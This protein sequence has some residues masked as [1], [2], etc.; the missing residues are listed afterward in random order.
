MRAS[1]TF[2]LV[3]ML[4]WAAAPLASAAESVLE[5]KHLTVRMLSTAERA[6]PGEPMIIGLQLTHDE[7]WHTY[8]ENPGDT[9]FETKVEWILPEGAQAGEL[10]WPMPERHMFSGMVYFGFGGE[11]LLLAEITPPETLEPG[12]TFDIQAKMQWLVCADVCIPGRGTA[13]LSLPVSDDGSAGKSDAAEMLL[14]AAENAPRPVS[15]EG[16][17]LE[18]KGDSVTLRAKTGSLLDSVDDG[19]AE[20]FPIT[21][22]VMDNA[23]QPAIDIEEGTVTIEGKTHKRLEGDPETFMGLLVVEQGGQKRAYEV[24]VGGEAAGVASVTADGAQDG[25]A[26]AA[27]AASPPPAKGAN[28]FVMIGLAMAGGVLLNLMPCVLPVLSLK[29]MSLIKSSQYTRQQQ[30]VHGLAY[31]AGIVL[32]FLILAAVLI[33]LRAAGQGIGWGFQLQSPWFVAALVY[34]LFALA[35]S[36]SGVLEIGTSLTRAGNL[37]TGTSGYSGSFFTGVLATVVATP[38]TAPFMGTAMGFALTQPAAIALIVFAAL[39]LGLALPF[40]LVSFIPAAVRYLPK[41]GAWMET[42][43]ELMAFPLYLTVIWLVWVLA[44]QGG[45]E[46]VALVLA[47]CVG[48]AFAF[49]LLRKSQGATKK[50]IVPRALAAASIMLALAI[51]PLMGSGAATGSGVIAQAEPGMTRTGQLAYTPAVLEESLATGKP[52]FVNMTADWCL[53]CKVNER[54]A[55]DTAEVKQA[56][57]E[58]EVIYIKGDWTTYNDDI[59]K[60]LDQFERSGVPLYVVYRPGAGEPEV[61]PQVLTP[62]IVKNALAAK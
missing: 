34:L 40:L 23:A 37:L 2:C 49:W 25:T 43:K 20:F 48:I 3:S 60:Y 19:K 30:Q 44:N 5:G 57:E 56:F 15:P 45:S 33:G 58:N 41:P 59:T 31:T 17:T 51:L 35:L 47:G 36:L 10:I 14:T 53:T 16:A 6:V 62:G 13:G 8:W 39:G 26:A 29:V 21:K 9:G 12:S 42:F 50:P 24:G 54:V 38:C 61:L 55:L 27:P 22:N 52:V 32:S 46:A 1:F 11:E 28:L 18:I 4:A 7:G